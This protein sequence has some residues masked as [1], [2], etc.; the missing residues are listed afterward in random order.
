MLQAG[1]AAAETSPWRN[2]KILADNVELIGNGVTK[3]GRHGIFSA[4]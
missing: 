4:G 2:K 3:S 1:T